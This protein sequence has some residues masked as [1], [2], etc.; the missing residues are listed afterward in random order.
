M[1][2]NAFAVVFSMLPCSVLWWVLI[3]V[4]LGSALTV[5]QCQVAGAIV[6]L[7]SGLQCWPLAISELLDVV[8]SNCTSYCGSYLRTTGLPVLR[9]T[10]EVLAIVR[11]TIY[12]VS[13]LVIVRATNKVLSPIVMLPSGYNRDQHVPATEYCLV[14]S[15]TVMGTDWL[16][17][18]LTPLWLL[19]LLTIVTTTIS[20]ISDCPSYKHIIYGCNRDQHAPATEGRDR[21]CSWTYCASS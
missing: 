13:P 11:T 9:T 20:T 2:S 16:V 18:C 4:L 10:K 12:N 21:A 6:R 5:V 7:L 1:V 3:G 14:F 15:C 8:N 19:E 17:S